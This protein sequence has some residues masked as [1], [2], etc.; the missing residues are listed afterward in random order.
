M[1]LI[2]LIITYFNK[3]NFIEHLL[4]CIVKNPIFDYEI[5]LINDGSNDYSTD[6]LKKILRQKKF[7]KVNYFFTENLGVSS[8][9]NL[10][11]IKAKGKYIWFLDGDD[12]LSI[13]WSQELLKIIKSDKDFDV[14]A[15][16]FLRFIDGKVEGV[17]WLSYKCFNGEYDYLNYI[18]CWYNIG[19]N[20]QYIFLNKFIKT[21]NLLFNENLFIGEDALFNVNAFIKANDI[22]SYR[23]P[24]YIQN[25]SIKNSLSRPNKNK[26]TKTIIN[27][28]HAH[29][30]I[31]EKVRQNI[32][33]NFVFVCDF[34]YHRL[35]AIKKIKRYD[36][37]S[38]S[39]SIVLRNYLRKIY[40]EYLDDQKWFDLGSYVEGTLGFKLNELNSFKE[41]FKQLNSLL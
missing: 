41:N 10:G 2:S 34:T 17:P 19:N 6:K 39:D 33:A 36:D 27:E 15:I 24:I 28:M 25:Q 23:V 18:D 11:I 9:K 12:Y 26:I 5:I 16:D 40:N 20:Y 8:A 31:K 29:S 14:M 1:P 3:S 35:Q 37:L 22:L 7:K 30:L 38:V 21:N 13:N 4:N 32:F